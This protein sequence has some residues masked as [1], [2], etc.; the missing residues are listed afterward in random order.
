MP[1]WPPRWRSCPTCSPWCSWADDTPALRHA[2]AE[3][4]DDVVVGVRREQQE[5]DARVGAAPPGVRAPCQAQ[6]LGRQLEP[7]AALLVGQHA[8]VEV[9]AVEAL[10]ERRRRDVHAGLAVVAPVGDA[11]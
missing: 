11:V 5:L 4:L 8:E 2:H 1:G 10:P 7:D 3:S 6:L 9:L